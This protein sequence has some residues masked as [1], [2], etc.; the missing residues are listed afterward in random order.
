MEQVLDRNVE[1]LSGG[2]L[3]RFAIAVVAAQDG[4]LGEGGGRGGVAGSR[5]V[6]RSL[7]YGKGNRACA[8]AAAA[9]LLLLHLEV[10][11]TGR[12][13]PAGCQNAHVCSSLLSGL[14]RCWSADWT[15]P[16]CLPLCA[17]APCSRRVHD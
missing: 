1:H 13:L 7:L 9:A 2:E 3:Q 10:Q 14:G 4:A 5:A 17:P 6:A 8:A 11:R 16:C 15:A 12:A